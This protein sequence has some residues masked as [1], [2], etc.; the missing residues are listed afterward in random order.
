[1]RS[2]HLLVAITGLTLT[3]G[4]WSFGQDAGPD[5]AQSRQPQRERDSRPRRNQI[6]P[7]TD[8]V[9]QTIKAAVQPTDEQMEQIIARYRQL[10][11]D[12]RE[13]MREI[14]PQRRRGGRQ[15]GDRESQQPRNRE[16][17]QPGNRQGQPRGNRQGRQDRQGMMQKLQEVMKP[18]NA[19]FLAD[20]RAML[21]TEQ[22]KAWDGCASGLDLMPQM[23]GRGGGGG[24]GASDPPRDLKSAIKHL[25]SC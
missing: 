14:M 1:M 25:I 21:N 11:R 7:G 22:Q 13:A 24:R 9:L 10:R 20:S 8:E 3:F 5:G 16:G 18:I 19:K 6:D 23:R 17:R 2:S 12:Q 15:S 4:S